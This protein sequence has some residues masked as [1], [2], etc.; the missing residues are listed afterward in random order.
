MKKSSIL[1]SV[2]VTAFLASVLLL[3]LARSKIIP[4]LQM[5]FPSRASQSVVFVP[6][7]DSSVQK[8]GSTVV[9]AKTCG[10]ELLLAE[11]LGAK[12]FYFDANLKNPLVKIDSLVQKE[13]MSRERQTSFFNIK[14]V[15]PGREQALEDSKTPE[16]ASHLFPVEQAQVS[17]FSEHTFLA[18]NSTPFGERTL[19]Y[20]KNG[21]YFSDAAFASV[22]DYLGA[23]KIKIS[24]QTIAILRADDT[25]TE[26]PR[27]KNGAILLKYPAQSWK[28]YNSVAFSELHALSVSEKN[29]FDY[30]SLMNGQGFFGEFD[31]ENP[32]ELYTAAVSATSDVSKYRALKK[33]FYVAMEQFLSGKQERLLSEAFSDEESKKKV[34]NMFTTCRRLF[35]EIETARAKISEKLADSLC[36]FALVAETASDFAKTPVEPLAPR[37]AESFVL[38]NMILSEDFFGTP[39]LILSL[40]I[41]FLIFFLLIMAVLLLIFHLRANSKSLLANERSFLQCVPK[42]FLKKI[43]LKSADYALDGQKS[44]ATILAASISGIQMLENLLNE[45]QLIAFLNYYLEKISSAVT[46]CGGI[47]ESYRNDEVISIFGSPIPSENHC[48]LATSAALSIKNLD[49]EINA[50]IQIYPKSPKIDGMSDD[51]YTAFFIL[52]HNERKIATR[53]G[54]FSGE[55]V[56][57]CLG[58]ESKKSYRIIDDS[59]KKA[60]LVKDAA[61]ILGNSG[62]LINETAFER[63]RDDYI[64][65]K[66]GKLLESEEDSMALSEILGDR[67]SDDEKL[68][69]YANYWNQAVDLKE[70]GETEKSLAIFKK[71]SA[72]RPSDRAAKYFIKSENSL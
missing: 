36:I 24:D 28:N 35:S 12:S 2:L 22:L 14:I 63:L 56:A 16:I 19:L 10:D 9:N 44:D 53:I 65:R 27:G 42:Q 23:Q 11:E 66:I 40:A 20:K 38:S 70:K 62:I 4:L 55:V 6:I 45:N 52:N 34:K 1:V 51:L 39:F 17:S 47:V 48:F 37:T 49:R 21:E 64:I 31:G 43:R 58:S 60:V 15:I 71:L 41:S 29:F 33:Q 68:W 57:A 5:L 8:S 72:A 18:G 30:L 69:N 54:I 46:Q 13:E 67:K 7:D 50:D 61:K 59:W 3:G 25:I 32:I 26:I